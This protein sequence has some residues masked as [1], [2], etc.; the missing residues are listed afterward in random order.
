MKKKIKQLI[1]LL[2]AFPI[3]FGF[4]SCSSVDYIS[5]G[6]T[7]QNKVLQ[8]NSEIKIVTYN[9]KAIYDKEEDQINNLN[10]FIKR[11]EFDFVVFQELFDESTRCEII[12]KSD[13]S[14]Y[15]T[16]ISRVDYNS[17]P[18]FIFQD[19]G[20]FM[21]SRYPRVDLSV[22]DFGDDINNSNGVVH[23]ILDKEY[24]KTND[25]LANKSVMG[26]L[27]YINDS[28]NIFLFT[29]HVQAIGSREHKE[30]QLVQIKNF[31]ENAVK[32][33]INSG[34]INNS[35]NLAVILAGDF[36]SNAYSIDRFTRLQ[37]LLGSPRDLHKEFH[38]TKEEYTF[39]FRDRKPSRRFDYIFAYD[40]IGNI[41]LKKIRLIDSGVEDI[42]DDN[43]ISISDHLA[44]KASLSI[45]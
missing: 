2:L 19:A 16:I 20:L 17:F 1:I 24:S 10:E 30:Y 31:I 43:Q 29:T 15:N 9:I 26:A 12:K 3:M 27:Y 45:N 32:V 37:M 39:G 33:T 21:M 35:E 28:T 11:G 34:V 8:N 36:N 23:T 6:S 38:G 18:E 22:T 13:K 25:F 5:N 7:D 40:K 14:F 44:L 42:K 41:P 4:L